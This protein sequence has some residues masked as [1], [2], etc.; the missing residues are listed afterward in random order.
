M[1]RPANITPALRRCRLS[2]P[3]RCDVLP[4]L[5][6]ITDGSAPRNVRSAADDE[7]RRCSRRVRCA[8]AIHAGQRQ[9]VRA[10][11]SVRRST[12]R[13]TQ[14][15][16]MLIMDA[17]GARLSSRARWRPSA[18]MRLQRCTIAGAGVRSCVGYAHRFSPPKTATRQ[19]ATVCAARSI[20]EHALSSRRCDPG[21]GLTGPGRGHH[22]QPAQ[23]LPVARTDSR[24]NGGPHT[25]HIWRSR[26]A[27]CRPGPP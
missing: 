3:P 17:A 11:S 5:A 20:Q 14:P 10:V 18:H 6:P 23:R 15:Q 21:T 24:V 27:D 1:G 8:G 2:L 19:P 12:R 22:D 7:A 25:P 9:P 4:M 26:W 13:L 16:G